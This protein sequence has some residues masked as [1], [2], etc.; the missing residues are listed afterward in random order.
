MAE[1]KNKNSAIGNFGIYAIS[2]FRKIFKI[3]KADMDRITKS[4]GDP[5]RIHQQVRKL[6]ELYGID[7]IDYKL[8]TTLLAASTQDA[9]AEEQKTLR[10]IIKLLGEI[11]EGNQ[12][13]YKP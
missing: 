11:P 12:K 7:N 3:G 5:T 13:S 4:S 1:H 8:L 9:K 2:K 10:E 6:R